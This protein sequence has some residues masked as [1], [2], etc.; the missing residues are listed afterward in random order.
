MKCQGSKVVI[1]VV[2]VNGL[3]LTLYVSAIVEYE[4]CKCKNKFIHYSDTSINFHHAP[5]KVQSN[6]KKSFHGFVANF[7]QMLQ[8]SRHGIIMFC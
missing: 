2:R 7:G 5:M 4:M 1:D 6:H 8:S 3:G